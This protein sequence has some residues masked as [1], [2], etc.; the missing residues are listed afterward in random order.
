M[1][2]AGTIVLQ[3]SPFE[4]CSGSA[5]M[6]GVSGQGALHLCRLVVRPEVLCQAFSSYAG[7]T[8][9]VRPFGG[10]AKVDWFASYAT[11]LSALDRTV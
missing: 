4:A 2:A 6:S 8:R 9:L 10:R 7:M 11:S 1:S 5:N 3:N